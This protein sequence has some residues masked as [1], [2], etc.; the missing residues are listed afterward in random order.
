MATSFLTPTARPDLT[1]LTDL[2]TTRTELG[3]FNLNQAAA[4]IGSNHTTMRELIHTEG[5][6]AFRMGRRW[7]IP[8][9]DLDNWLTEQAA[10]RARIDLT[11]G[12]A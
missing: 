4:Y 3:C 12:E 10:K 11:G 6:P 7:M 1:D 5:F 8:R 2:T 9:R